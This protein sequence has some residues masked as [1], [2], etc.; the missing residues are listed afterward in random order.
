MEGCHYFCISF[1]SKEGEEM[2]PIGGDERGIALVSALVLTLLA[3]V[4]VGIVMKMVLTGT[5]FSGS[6]K[7]YTSSLASTKGGVEDF[8]FSL[9]NSSWVQANDTSWLSGHSC[10]LQ[11]DT[12]LWSTAC[13][14]LC[15]PLSNCT[16][17]T[18]PDDIV[19]NADWKK[20]YGGYTVYAKIVDCKAV[21]DGFIST[22]D[23][24]GRSSS[25]PEVAWLTI[26]YE[27]EF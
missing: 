5:Y 26:V 10:K 13:S 20:D 3:L 23:L 12:S 27:Q 18:S 9:K 25:S 7:N 11:R 14:S 2:I 16:S 15:N 19:D 4:L 22:I 1:E 21:S 24:V 6:L 17:D 8:V